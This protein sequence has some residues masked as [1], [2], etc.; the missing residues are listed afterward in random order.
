MS[1]IGSHTL[2]NQGKSDDWLTP[3]GILECLGTFDLD[4]CASV[5]QP[6]A[7]AIEQW[8]DHGL[9]RGWHGFV[10]CNPPYGRQT[11][12]W[13]AKMADHGNGIALIFARTETAMFVEHVWGRATAIVFLHGRLFFHHPVSG[14][15]A[16]HNSGGP[17]CLVAYG[18]EAV[19]RLWASGLDGSIVSGWQRPRSE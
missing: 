18:D 10:W 19:R 6:W 15:R 7:T 17:S 16:A 14:R 12:D 9:D 11:G 8:T 5:D 2:P 1:G 13:L 3:P 4:P